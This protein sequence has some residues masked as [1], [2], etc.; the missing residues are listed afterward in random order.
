[1][2]SPFF[3]SNFCALITGGSSAPS[4]GGA[5]ITM[6][7]FS[8][9]CARAS[10]QSAGIN[11][12]HVAVATRKFIAPVIEFLPDPASLDPKQLLRQPAVDRGG[13]R[14]AELRL[15][16]DLHRLVLPDRERHVGAHHHTVGAY[17]LDDKSQH[18]RV[19]HNAVG[20]KERQ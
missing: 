11:I 15:G 4:D 16:D 8:S 3:S 17:H 18:P 14:R 7:S 10:P 1:M 6:V 13:L 12:R 20:I 5:K 9:V 2:S 19:V